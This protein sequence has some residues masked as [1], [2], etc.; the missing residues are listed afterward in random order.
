[1][2]Y[3]YRSIR[4][5]EDAVQLQNDLDN[6]VSWENKWSMQFHPDKCFLLKVTNKRNIIDTKY[7]IHGET[8]KS[9]D[10]AK[11]LG[12]VISKNLTWNKHI[13]LITS[14]ATNTRLFLQRNLSWADKDT[15]LMCYKTFTRPLVEY[16]STVWD[17]IENE[18][19]IH[20]IEM[21]QRKSIRWIAREWGYDVS[22]DTIRKSLDLETLE[23]RRYK[24]KIKMLHDILSGRK[25]VDSTIHPKRQRC[26]NVKYQPIQGRI[27]CYSNSFFP[28]TVQYWNELP[29]KIANVMDENEFKNIV[30]KISG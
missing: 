23:F 20:Q 11:Y 26:S 8:L 10:K 27:K 9:V 13:D 29:S 7:T 14:K 24:A 30:D 16:A 3:L 15:R 17:P 28:S 21:I 6:L 12:I 4:T 5:T 19:L 22:P 1:M 18:S 2:I 25:F